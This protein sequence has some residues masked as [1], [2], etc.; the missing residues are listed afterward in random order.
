MH[1]NNFLFQISGGTF[2]VIWIFLVRCSSRSIV[3][4]LI[5]SKKI[6]K[7]DKRKIYFFSEKKN[8]QIRYSRSSLKKKQKNLQ[9][10]FLYT[11][12]AK[13]KNSQ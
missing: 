5:V 7:Y 13:Q 10:F 1:T 12:I 8:F 3:I 4:F 9:F 6:Q 11:K 2:H